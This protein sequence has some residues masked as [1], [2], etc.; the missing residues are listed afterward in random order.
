MSA[1]NQKPL[2]I[3]IVDDDRIICL[4]QHKTLLK[5]ELGHKI[6]IFYNG[7]DALEYVREPRDRNIQFLV[8]LD[9]NMPIMN[10]WEFLDHCS[11]DSRTFGIKVAMVT[12][13]INK[14]DRIKAMEYP[15]VVGFY[16]KPFTLE[17]AREVVMG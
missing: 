16:E 6:S 2:E 14:S 15:Q 7:K 3:L 12:S 4:L 13:S 5:L 8:L 1:Q 10:G 17:K 9:I 11:D